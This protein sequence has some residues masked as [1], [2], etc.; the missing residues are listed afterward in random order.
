MPNNAETPGTTR[1]QRIRRLLSSLA[2]ILVVGIL[3]GI[4]VLLFAPHQTSVSGATIGP[5]TTTQVQIDGFKMTFGL[6]PGPY[7]VSE[8]LEAK[9]TFTNHTTQTQW[10]SSPFG[11]N[12]CGYATGIDIQGGVKPTF[13]LPTP[14]G[15]SCPADI[16]QAL[17]VL[18]GQILSTS[19]YIALQSSGPITLTSTIDFLEPTN[20]Q[21]YKRIKSP[22]EDHWP[23]LHIHIASQIPQDRQLT[24][25]VT[26]KSITVDASTSAHLQY[27]FGVTCTNGP[28]SGSEETGNYGWQPLKSSTVNRPACSMKHITWNYAIGAPGYAIASGKVKSDA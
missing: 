13:E 20:N 17:K 14:M 1:N 11:I 15:H 10:A 28:G 23:T 9:I 21:S 2:A 6:T 27:I 4:A 12:P 18:P 3:I 7:F 24:T 8:L 16:G 26:E 19:K 25:H 5:L 22:L